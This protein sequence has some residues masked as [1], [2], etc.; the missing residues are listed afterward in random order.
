MWCF[1]YLPRYA[2]V[3]VDDRGGVVIDARL[4]ALVDRDHH[5]HRYFLAILCIRSVV[6]HQYRLRGVVPER[7]DCS[8]RSREPLKISLKTGIRTP[9]ARFFDERQMDVRRRCCVF[10]MLQP[11]S[12]AY[13][14]K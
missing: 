6:G 5:R 12:L 2:V 3:S 7:V 13:L 11:G 9:F 8:D 14:P 1:L 4:L 10:S